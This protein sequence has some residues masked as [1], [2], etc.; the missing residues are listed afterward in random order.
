M[1]GFFGLVPFVLAVLAT[2]LLVPAAANADKLTVGATGILCYKE[3]CPRRGIVD[4]SHSEPALKALLWSGHTLPP[5]E[6]DEADL[7]RIE[8]AW[9][10]SESVLIEGKFESGLLHVERI[11][12]ADR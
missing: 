9:N 10:N 8:R 3:P 12:D 7:R 4:A 1:R 5:M 2:G 11:L 6:G